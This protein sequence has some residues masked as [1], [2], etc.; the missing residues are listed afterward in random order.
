VPQPE[1]TP[2]EDKNIET[3]NF[4]LFF[5]WHRIKTMSEE[6]RYNTLF[7]GLIGNLLADEKL[8]NNVW[9]N[10]VVTVGKLDSLGN[11]KS[12]ILNT[13]DCTEDKKAELFN[14]QI[15]GLGSVNGI[16][17]WL[18]LAQSTEDI[19]TYLTLS[20]DIS[21]YFGVS[22]ADVGLINRFIINTL[23]TAKELFNNNLKCPNNKCDSL[24]LLKKQISQSA[25]SKNT[26]QSNTLAD[27][28][29]LFF[30]IEY[31]AFYED[32]FKDLEKGEPYKDLTW[33][34]EQADRF[35]NVDLIHLAP[36]MK[37][38]VLPHYSNL[39]NLRE[40][41]KTF[42][43]ANLS[44]QDKHL[45]Y[46]QQMDKV[47]VMP[48]KDK[49]FEAL[50]GVVDRFK[51]KSAEQAEVTCGYIEH[52][53][54][55]MVLED[56]N[57]TFELFILSQFTAENMEK[58]LG[59]V[60]SLVEQVVHKSF[61][62][63]TLEQSADIDCAKVMGTSMSIPKDK[64]E[65]I[66][67]VYITDEK[68]DTNRFLFDLYDN[69]E[70]A[71]PIAPFDI[72]GLQ[73][74]T[75]CTS[76]PGKAFTYANLLNAL[77]TF[78][79][80]LYGITDNNFSVTKLAILQMVKS[81]LSNTKNKYLSEDTHPQGLSIHP[82]DPVTFARPFEMAFFVD[83]YKLDSTFLDD[84]NLETL[85]DLFNQG[86]LM[87]PLV[88]FYTV[89]NARNGDFNF[90]KKFMGLDK[91]YYNSFWQYMVLF[92]REY[93]LQGFFLKL[94]EKEIND[95][96]HSPFIKDIKERQI[97]MGGDPSTMF[98]VSVRLQ[99][100]DYEFEKY[101][102]KEDLSKLDNFY[103]LNGFEKITNDLPVF[104]GNKV[105]V[106]RT[107]PWNA[108]LMLNGCDNFCPEFQF[109]TEDDASLQKD[110]VS[111]ENERILKV[112][113][114]PLN[115]TVTYNYKESRKIDF[116]NCSVDHYKLDQDQYAAKFR[117]YHQEQVNGFFNMT[118]V[119]NFPIM[120]SQDH[121]HGVD[122]KISA[123]YTYL[124]K[125]GKAITPDEERD[126]G[127][128][129][130]EQRTRGVTRMSLNL[131]FNLEIH[132]D[133]LF[134]GAE[135]E[136][137]GLRQDPELP[138]LVPLYNL[139][140]WT[141]LPEKGWKNIFGKVSMANTFLEKYFAIFVSLFIVFLCIWLLLVYLFRREVLKTKKD[142]EYEKIST[143]DE[144][145]S[146]NNDVN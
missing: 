43:L 100:A 11:A 69:C 87:N 117:E 15:F 94:S 2:S 18:N 113:G 52:I 34:D 103:G 1:K 46:Y 93:Y 20:K 55:N 89:N 79:E 98:P 14:D 118:T 95:G 125:D 137:L 36:M 78:L 132:E 62:G 83:K 42:W 47:R 111:E 86:S 134:V 80:T 7:S 82:W 58:V 131:H 129:E 28:K 32:N 38:D 66:C 106:H 40:G 101:T 41:C 74:Q 90:F 97:L 68:E 110:Q 145:V 19:K 102:G 108:D 37:P 109:V 30:P 50:K 72:T 128:Y 126:G 119:F 12:S 81:T 9:A 17:K 26:L 21:E 85:S 6:A 130:T 31:C 61:I 124:D 3:L 44:G 71:N 65:K 116:M 45:G 70:H 60:K 75:F 73:L 10:G 63:F 77:Y 99:Q 64:I 121:L 54:K 48:H 123:K 13:L 76:S 84:L 91:K 53:Y 96:V 5:F 16:Q 104:D 39:K 25:I 57:G 27:G 120:I 35:Y 56:Q 107:N 143:E 115:R 88:L 92:L 122:P 49:N 23:K 127:F 105:S 33:T 67:A 22:I 29:N 4:P 59:Q 136:I 138:F 51:F 141:N 112:Y 144:S 142:D 133:L 135:D 8:L 146:K 114:P 24:F 139:D 140:F